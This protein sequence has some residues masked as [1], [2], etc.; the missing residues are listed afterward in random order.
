MNWTLNPNLQEGEAIAYTGPNAQESEYVVLPTDEGAYE[1]MRRAAM[2]P[3]GFLPLGEFPTIEEAANKAG[4]GDPFWEDY[5]PGELAREQANREAKAAQE[6]SWAAELARYNALTPEQQRA[7]DFARYE[8]AGYDKDPYFDCHPEFARAK[9]QADAER[10]ADEQAAI[11][12]YNRY[13][14]P[15]M[16]RAENVYEVPDSKEWIKRHTNPAYQ[17]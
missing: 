11:A 3:G 4:E 8:A 13:V 1:L 6:A 9:R 15:A 17:P 2:V 12:E 7:E 16:L 5:A 10:A 14:T